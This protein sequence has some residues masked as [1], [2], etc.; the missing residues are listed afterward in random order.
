MEGSSNN[1]AIE[2]YNPSEEVVDLS[3]YAIARVSNSPD[4]VGEHEYWDTFDAGASIQPKGVFVVCHPSADQDIL[5]KCDMEF[6]NFSNGDDGWCLTHGPEA[7]HTVLDCVGDFNGDPG[8]GWA[9]AGV[10]EATKDHTLMRKHAICAGNNGDW[11]ASAGTNADDSEWEVLAQDS[12]WD[13][14]NH[15]GCGDDCNTEYLLI[16]RLAVGE[17]VEIGE[18]GMYVGG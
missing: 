17:D 1:K 14:G 11:I 9:V 4:T 15:C 10:D 5:D 13:L 3:L 12:T 7:D 16:Y 18:L 2:I 8:S 6:S